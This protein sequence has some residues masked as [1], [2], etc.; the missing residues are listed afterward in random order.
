MAMSEMAAVMNGTARAGLR[1][2]VSRHAHAV[3]LIS[4]FLLSTL[5]LWFASF[6]PLHDYPFHLAR[7][8]V[9]N[10][11]LHGGPR[12]QF[13]QWGSLMLPNLAMDVVVLGLSQLMPVL[14]AGRV[15][16]ALTLLL[17]FGGVAFLHR[18]LT[19]R[20]SLV[21]LGAAVLLFNWIFLM[22]FLNYLFGVALLLWSLGIHW[23]LRQSP[24]WLRLGIGTASALLL[25]F[26]HFVALGLYALA[27]GGIALR[28]YW[29]EGRDWRLPLLD[30]LPFLAPFAL[31]L[32]RSPTAGESG[33]RVSFHEGAEFIPLRAIGHKIE[34]ILKAP[35]SGDLMIDAISA[36]MVA[37]GLTLLLRLARVRI[38]AP[39]RWA[40]AILAAT[41]FIAPWGLFGGWFVD[42][43]VPIVAALVALA[44]TRVEIDSTVWRRAMVA[45]LFALLAVRAVGL[46]MTWAE[47]DRVHGRFVAVMRA[48]PP[49]AVLFAAIGGEFKARSYAENWQPPLRHISSLAMALGP[50]FVPATWANPA[51]QPSVV[52]PAYAAVQDLQTPD[53]WELHD[54]ADVAAAVRAVRR[55]GRAGDLPAAPAG[56]PIAFLF[57]L[58]PGEIDVTVGGTRV[59][60][61]DPRFVLLA[62]DPAT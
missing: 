17:L 57:L 5:P 48:I 41:Y 43:R 9:L 22:G 34:H 16:V 13:Y 8:A 1:A 58:H 33:H 36:V 19:G 6:P 2:A 46:S 39:L 53:P 12:A 40:A 11:L 47:A 15:F 29:H 30:A 52:R 18:G 20:R 42:A 14:L 25:F 32:L 51:Q 31:F 24:A 45:G 38:V 56:Q 61:R 54:N 62:V 49:G 23:R 3:L 50:V 60:A 28:R 10:D 7:M 44:A 37:F 26:A 59:I 4:A 27:V 55:L 21:P 35:L